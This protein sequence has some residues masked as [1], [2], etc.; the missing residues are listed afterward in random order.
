MYQHKKYGKCIANNVLFSQD[1][2]IISFNQFIGKVWSV[3][4]TKSEYGKISVESVEGR[5]E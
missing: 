5:Q 1:I 3:K 2:Y 4:D